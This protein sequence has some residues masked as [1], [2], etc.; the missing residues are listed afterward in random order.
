MHGDTTSKVSSMG[1]KTKLSPALQTRLLAAIAAGNYIHTACA[2]VGI[3][4]STYSRWVVKGEKG[5]EPYRTFCDG[6][7]RAAEEAQVKFVERIEQHSIGDW[8]AAAFLLE[9]RNRKEWG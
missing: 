1:R 3:D 5:Q 4:K 9:R 2:A 6:L 7:M 8:R